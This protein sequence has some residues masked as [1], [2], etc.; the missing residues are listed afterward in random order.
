VLEVVAWIC[1]VYGLILAGARPVVACAITGYRF[2]YLWLSSVTGSH[3]AVAW[4]RRCC[5]SGAQGPAR[6]LSV[7]DAWCKSAQIAGFPAFLAGATPQWR[8][9]A[10]ANRILKR[11][12][13]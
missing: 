7:A 1:V 9:S 8:I 2:S 10:F 13:I 6:R 3:R 5:W 11:E 12:E 4:R